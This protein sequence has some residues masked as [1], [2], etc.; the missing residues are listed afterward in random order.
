MEMDFFFLAITRTIHTTYL[1][2]QHNINNLFQFFILFFC[3]AEIIRVYILCVPYLYGILESSENRRISFWIVKN[4]RF[5]CHKQRSS[6][7][8]SVK[9]TFIGAMDRKNFVVTIWT[10]KILNYFYV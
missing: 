2:I 10:G 4:K 8:R 9:L 7:L 6:V 3:I 1:L 5:G